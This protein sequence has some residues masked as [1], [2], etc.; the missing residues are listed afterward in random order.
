[1]QLVYSRPYENQYPV[2]YSYSCKTVNNAKVSK[3]EG[4]VFITIVTIVSHPY[5]LEFSINTSQLSAHIHRL[6]PIC[7]HPDYI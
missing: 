2:N 1:M 5:F 7:W 6:N 4:N 3:N